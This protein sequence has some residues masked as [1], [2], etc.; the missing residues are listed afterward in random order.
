MFL[1][2][3]FR[4]AAAPTPSMTQQVHCSD[5]IGSI[6]LGPQWFL[7]ETATC[8]HSACTC[9]WH[10]FSLG[11]L[12]DLTEFW[13]YWQNFDQKYASKD[14]FGYFVLLQNAQWFI[15]VLEVMCLNQSQFLCFVGKIFIVS[16]AVKNG[17][18]SILRIS[19]TSLN[20]AACSSSVTIIV[21]LFLTTYPFVQVPQLS[22]LLSP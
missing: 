14:F 15:S 12:H 21:F 19:C 18:L 1:R 4:R 5:E 13:K 8:V 20:T 16:Q 9:A 11:L 6:L 10:D 17:I 7:Q 2:D 22:C 3:S